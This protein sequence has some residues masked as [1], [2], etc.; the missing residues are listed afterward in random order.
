[1]QVEKNVGKPDRLIRLLISVVLFLW[2]LN[3][4]PIFGSITTTIII[5]AF[6]ILNAVTA[7]KSHCL[8]YNLFGVST[9]KE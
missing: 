9:Y 4:T 8:V 2:L 3:N 6:T 5:T 1:M 7:Y